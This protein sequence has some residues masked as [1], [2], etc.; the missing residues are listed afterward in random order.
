MQ[1]DANDEFGHALFEDEL[2][3]EEGLHGVL[4]GEIV[5]GI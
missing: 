1:V 5:V 3:L 4:L 2:D